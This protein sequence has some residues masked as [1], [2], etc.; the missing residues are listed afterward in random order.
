MTAALDSSVL[1]GLLAGTASDTIAT[2]DQAAE[3]LR[4]VRDGIIT[5]E[6]PTTRG[7]VHFSRELDAGDATWCAE[8]LMARAIA[9]SP[10]S[11]REAEVLFE[12]DEA[13]AERSDGGR[14]DDLFAKA[15]AHHTVSAS[16]IAVPSRALA[17]APQT[18]IETWAPA[19]ADRIDPQVLE[20]LARQMRTHRRANGTLVALAATLL[21]AAA[22]PLAQSLPGVVD[23]GM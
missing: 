12:I 22:L 14:F 4:W 20:W 18:P 19:K 16:G 13:A 8:I 1:A 7:R 3:A 15:V 11:R 6:G 5:G 9:R 17:L 21:G 10:V 23:L 2:S